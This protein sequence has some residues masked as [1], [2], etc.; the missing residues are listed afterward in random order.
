[1]AIARD[2]RLRIALLGL[3]LACAGLTGW[4]LVELLSAEYLPAEQF[5]LALAMIVMGGSY[6]A[7]G[8]VAWR[9]RPEKRLGPLMVLLGSVWL[10]A[11]AMGV[12]WP[13]SGLLAT[14]GL[15]VLDGWVILLVFF[16]LAFPSGRL[17]SR[18]GPSA[19]GDVRVHRR[20]AGGGLAALLRL[21]AGRAGERAAGLAGRGRRRRDR[22]RTA[23]DLR[24]RDVRRRRGARGP[25]AARLA[26]AAARPDAHRSPAAPPCSSRTCSWC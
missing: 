2:A 14:L 26:S 18:T 12:V 9:H 23:R 19:R 7:C 1:M 6:M 13:P 10:A 20:P 3:W 22:H 8:L 16:L 17:A 15:L 11:L 25:L 4:L 5:V 21:R 24:V